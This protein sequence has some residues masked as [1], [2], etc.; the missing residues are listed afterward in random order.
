[1]V[2]NKNV[3][4][5]NVLYYYHIVKDTDSDFLKIRERD[6]GLLEEIIAKAEYLPATLLKWQSMKL[7]LLCHQKPA[8]KHAI[9]LPVWEPCHHENNSFCHSRVK[10][11]SFTMLFERDR[12]KMKAKE[13]EVKSF[14]GRISYIDSKLAGIVL[15]RCLRIKE[16]T[17]SFFY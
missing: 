14:K 16:S 7:N 9:Q 17:M 8:K 6:S 2:L 10:L 5:C 1:M 12:K 3:L 15:V 4:Y 13:K 11:H